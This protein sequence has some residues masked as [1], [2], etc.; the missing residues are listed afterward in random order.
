MKKATRI[1][2]I[3]DMVLRF[4]MITP[5]IFGILALKRLQE[6]DRRDGIHIGFIIAMLFLGSTVGGIFMLCMTEEQ[7]KM[8]LNAPKEPPA[9]S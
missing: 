5:I 9:E 4:W 7:W 6:T 8:P 2:I 1:V 3:I